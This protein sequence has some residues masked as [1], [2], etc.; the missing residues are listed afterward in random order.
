[1]LNQINTDKLKK[2]DNLVLYQFTDSVFGTIE[3]LNIGVSGRVMFS[4]RKL[5]IALGY[6]NIDHVVER[7]SDK[8]KFLLRNSNMSSKM[9]VFK[10]KY[11]EASDRESPLVIPDKKKKRII[12]E[13]GVEFE[14]KTTV[15]DCRP[16]NSYGETFITDHAAYRLMIR[17]KKPFAVEFQDWL[18]GEVIPTIMAGDD[19]VYNCIDESSH[20]KI[21]K[22]ISSVIRNGILPMSLHLYRAAP[23]KLEI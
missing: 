23:C 15:E 14:W 17:S 21:V 11:M 2:M 10:S 7:V 16:I 19:Y 22:A 20:K 1:M 4:C 8:H 13:D 3:I 9:I 6:K 12:I 5:A 18:F